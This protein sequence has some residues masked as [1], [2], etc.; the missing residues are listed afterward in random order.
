M[1]FFP[2]F[3]GKEDAS[4]FG[5]EVEDAGMR[6][7]MEGGYVLTRPRFTRPP[8]RTW[9]TGFTSIDE[10]NFQ[11]FVQFFNEYGTYKGFTYVV[12]TTNENVNVRFSQKPT[13]KYVGIGTTSMWDIDAK[14]EE[15]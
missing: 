11:A 8:R 14:L 12:P 13:F 10:V 7:E 4:K 2:T 6:S 3:G 5:M 15:I 1:P 9:S